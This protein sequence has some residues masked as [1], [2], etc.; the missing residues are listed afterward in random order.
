MSKTL[1]TTAAVGAAAL[2][3]YE[4]VLKPWQ[5]RWGAT[6][7]EAAGSLAGDEHVAEPATQVTRA[8]TIDAPPHEVWPWLV[9]IGANRAG[10][11]SYDWLENAVGLDIHSADRIERDWQELEVGDGV[12]ANRDGSAGWYV[13]EL[14]P[15]VVMVLK[16]ADFKRDRVM[17][18][19]EGIGF[20]F[21]WTFALHA[22]PHDR[23][24]LFVRE[25]VGFGKPL[26]RILFGPVGFASFVMTRKMMLGIKQR[27]ERSTPVD[28][29]AALPLVR[30]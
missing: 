5:E 14:V 25:R 16:M 27:A 12:R 15:D 6:D 30:I 18:R 8:I 7:A 19:T 3:A 11:Y 9:Q 4:R 23:T 24:R 2:A 22:L 29:D 28:A 26:T 17:R 1:I 10:F 13:V 21:G 20:E